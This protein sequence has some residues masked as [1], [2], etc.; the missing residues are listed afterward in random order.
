MSD[1]EIKMSDQLWELSTEQAQE[2]LD[3]FLKTEREA[4]P[5]LKI[6]AIDLDYSQESVAQ[7]AHY[8]ASEIEAGRFDEEQQNLWFMRLGYYFGEALCREKPGLSWGLGDP[9]YAF[10]NHP[11]VS[12]F[13]DDEEAPMITIC[14]NMIRSVGEGRSP[15][16][17][18]DN[19]IK[20][21]FDTKST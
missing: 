8:I 5:A 9:E 11:V 18:I 2:V 20:L 6:G 13:A 3:A 14:K 15:R 16:T 19:G 4:F 17:R 12:G 1:N 21:W 10:A 7:A